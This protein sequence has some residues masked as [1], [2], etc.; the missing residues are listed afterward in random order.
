MESERDKEEVEKVRQVRHRRVA[1]L[2]KA[3]KHT[4]ILQPEVVTQG[5]SPVRQPRVTTPLPAAGATRTDPPL[6][7][8]AAPA[9]RNR[10]DPC[11]GIEYWKVLADAPSDVA[12]TTGGAVPLPVPCETNCNDRVNV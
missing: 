4:P 12:T 5:V 2:L 6:M 8:G 11:G 9:V 3:Q 10:N 1:D 7:V